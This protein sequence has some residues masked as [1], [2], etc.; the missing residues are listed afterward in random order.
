MNWFEFVR[1]S[2]NDV[3]D[4]LMFNVGLFE[5]K[6]RVLG[7]DCQYMNMLMFVRCSKNDVQVWLMFHKMVFDTSL[8]TMKRDFL[9]WL[10]E[11]QTFLLVKVKESFDSVAKNDKRN[12]LTFVEEMKI[13]IKNK[14]GFEIVYIGTLNKLFICN[15]ILLCSIEMS[16]FQNWI[17]CLWDGPMVNWP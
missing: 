8:I 14:K 15:R 1:C 4:H 7:F 16:F 12:F 9:G 3:W 6:N 2:K 13:L 5:G 17:Y 10:R 11:N